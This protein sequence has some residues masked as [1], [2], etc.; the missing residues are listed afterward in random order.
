MHWKASDEVKME[1]T[2]DVADLGLL[3]FNHGNKFISVK[4]SICVIAILP[5]HKLRLS[6]SHKITFW[7]NW[8]AKHLLPPSIRCSPIFTLSMRISFFCPSSKKKTKSQ[9][10]TTIS[11]C[12][13]S[14]P[15]RKEMGPYPDFADG[16]PEAFVVTRLTQGDGIELSFVQVGHG[17][18]P[19]LLTQ[20]LGSF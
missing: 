1:Y 2:V 18:F 7:K 8:T 16:M 15:P 20:R 10:I 13:A 19:L 5:N 17:S 12:R 3:C 14:S 11:I 6:I 9:S 4:C